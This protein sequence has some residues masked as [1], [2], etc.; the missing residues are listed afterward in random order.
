[1]I[2][3]WVPPELAT[4][5]VSPY[6]PSVSRGHNATPH[7]WAPAVGMPAATKVEFAAWKI[8]TRPRVGFVR[9]SARRA[10]GARHGER[11]SGDAA[12][13]CVRPVAGE[14][15]HDDLLRDRRQRR[16]PERELL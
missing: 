5:I 3:S 12:V 7:G 1:M 13:V 6:A 14:R 10:G 8:S 4:T 9:Y 16:E 15:L 2:T 11:L